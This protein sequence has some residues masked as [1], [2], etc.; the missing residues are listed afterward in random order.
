M[1]KRPKS[2]ALATVPEVRL[3]RGEAVW[4]RLPVL[5]E[6][7]GRKVGE[8]AVVR[9]QSRLERMHKRG[10]VTAEQ[11]Q[12]GEKFALDM[13]QAQRS[14]R[15]CLDFDIAQG[16]D[17][18]PSRLGAHRAEAEMAVRDAMQVMGLMVWPVVVWVAV[19]GRSAKDWAL[20]NGKAG[21]DGL[22]VLRVGLD[23]LVKHYAI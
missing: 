1:P 7:S 2:E 17:V 22:A 8:V 12:A 21:R 14:T 20:S 16:G 6:R 13:E 19:D 23:A 11:R 10:E 5:D 3:Q 4:D 15:S 18:A 9:V